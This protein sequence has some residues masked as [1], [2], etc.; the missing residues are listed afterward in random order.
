MTQ[1][2]GHVDKGKATRGASI[3]AD[4]AVAALSNILT[5]GIDIHRC[6]AAQA[7]GWMRNPACVDALVA[8]LL[9][10]DEDV[11]AD[12]AGGLALLPN[13]DAAAPLLESLLGDPCI[14]VKLSA[15]ET[16]GRLHHGEAVPWLRRL[17]R[18]RDEE[19]VWDENEFHASGWDDWNDI[20]IKSI[21]ALAEI[22]DQD[23]VS[24]IVAALQDE[25]AQNLTEVAFAALGR[26]GEP[27][28]EALKGFL[29]DGDVRLRE[30]AA[31]ML[32]NAEGAA[33]QGDDEAR[34]DDA[35]PEEF[36]LEAEAARLGDAKQPLQLRLLAIEKLKE[37][38][39]DEA[40]EVLAAILGDG[41]RQIRLSAMSALVALAAARDDWPN[42]AG[43]ALL[44][45]LRGELVAAPEPDPVAE[46]EKPQ[47]EPQAA[48]EQDSAEESEP[49]PEIASPTSTLSAMLNAQ[50]AKS[51]VMTEPEPGV[52]LTRLDMERLALTVRNTAKRIVPVTPKV[53]PHSDV[54][55]FAARVLGDLAH[56]DVA[57]ELAAALSHNDREK[58]LAAADSLARISEQLGRLPDE[59]VEAL[60]VALANTD[61]D[62]RLLVVRALGGAGD[63]DITKRLVRCLRDPDG[64][65]R[66]EAVR[67]LVRRSAVGP[68]V[69]RLLKDSEPM[70]RLAAA[71]AIAAAHGADALERLA[72]FAFAF[73][74]YHRRQTARLLREIDAS[75]AS[76]RFVAVLDDP[77]QKPVWQVA[78][79]ALEEIHRSNP[80]GNGQA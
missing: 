21:E 5:G 32:A 73:E 6:S 27:G 16:L 68:E 1:V 14:E 8:A 60:L 28:L 62:L 2:A 25:F 30:H 79:E 56:D 9:D 54:P 3:S 38:G 78:I 67:G 63:E 45:A 22:G 39:G 53:S 7:L 58:Q 57:V 13:P 76:D 29:D 72:D 55:R 44:A 49:D 36:D 40:V 26:L 46:P 12:A 23:A 19:V 65:I 18:G 37:A 70:V 74:G 10:E 47:P 4:R 48:E 75:A 24:D 20:Q 77:E 11:R 43:D 17:V 52:E 59:A 31:A 34:E 41:E 64:F 66:V 80:N 50:P 35:E 51:R 71:E 33:A 69:A 61:R 15:I 42:A